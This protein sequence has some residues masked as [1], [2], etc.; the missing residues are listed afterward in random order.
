[1]VYHI[2]GVWRLYG[3]AAL[4]IVQSPTFYVL[5]C[6]EQHDCRKCALRLGVWDSVFRLWSTCGICA[7]MVAL[8]FK[9]AIILWISQT[10]E[11]R[12]KWVLPSLKTQTAQAADWFCDFEALNVHGNWVWRELPEIA[13]TVCRDCRHRATRQW[14]CESVLFF[15][16]ESGNQMPRGIARRTRC[17]QDYSL[18]WRACHHHAWNNV[19]FKIVIVLA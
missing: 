6:P 15:A 4:L 1:M 18:S 17:D 13:L 9:E 14:H 12:S 16:Y 5:K 2:L 7:S 19:A 8:M 11:V 3:T 10:P